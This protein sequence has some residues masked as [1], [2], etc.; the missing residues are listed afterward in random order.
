MGGLFFRVV[1]IEIE[2]DK[3]GMYFGGRINRTGLAV[4]CRERR[5]SRK[6]A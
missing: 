3:F 5:T 6:P 4:G 1:G 2:V